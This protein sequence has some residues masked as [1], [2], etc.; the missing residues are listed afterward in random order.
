MPGQWW[1]ATVRIKSDTVDA[2]C[3]KLKEVGQVTEIRPEPEDLWG[4]SDEYPKSDW[5]YDVSNGDTILGYWDWV[6]H[7]LDQDIEDSC[8]DGDEEDED[9]G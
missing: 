5:I 3:Q 4:Q 7:R 6:E 8:V 9:D 2:A 1:V